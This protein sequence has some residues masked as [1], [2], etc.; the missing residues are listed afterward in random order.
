MKSVEFM[1]AVTD[2][3]LQCH[4]VRVEGSKLTLAFSSLGW[5]KAASVHSEIYS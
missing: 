2:E 4:L 5:R 3:V 1:T